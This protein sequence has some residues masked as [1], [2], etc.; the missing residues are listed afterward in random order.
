MEDLERWDQSR[1]ALAENKVQQ[2]QRHADQYGPWCTGLAPVPEAVPGVEAVRATLHRRVERDGARRWV[3]NLSF[4]LTVDAVR[5]WFPAASV[6]E[7]VGIDPGLR[8]PLTWASASAAHSLQP[9]LVDLGEFPG[10]QGAGARALR[11]AIWDRHAAGYQHALEDVLRHRTVRLE[12]TDWATLSC[13]NPRFTDRAAS[14]YL[15]TMLDHLA[16]LAP[17]TGSVIEMVPSQHTSLTCSECGY[18]HSKR[19][20]GTFTC[21]NPDPCPYSAQVDI[22]AALN[23]AQAMEPRRRRA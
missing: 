21:A 9:A 10:S 14:N 20:E 11:Q 17:L 22:N 23:I 13:S 19:Q 3:C 5:T 12:Q 15:F 4:T 7:P 8:H 6:E 2:L 16:A 1:G 18:L